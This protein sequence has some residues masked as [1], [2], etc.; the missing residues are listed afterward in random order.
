MLEN[1]AVVTTVFC[2][3]CV[4]TTWD[5]T[6]G[7]RWTVVRGVLAVTALPSGFVAAPVFGPEGSVRSLPLMVAVLWPPQVVLSFVLG[8]RGCRLR[9]TTSRSAERHS[10]AVSLG[11]DG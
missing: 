9:W 10:G 6:G 8:M 2:T 11:G 1:L 7:P 4:M 5:D 3:G